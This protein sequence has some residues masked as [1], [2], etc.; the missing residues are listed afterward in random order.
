MY[1]YH[2]ILRL[3]HWV[4]ALLVLALLASGMTV[5]LLG[6][7]GVT[8]LLGEA[9]RDML[10]EYHKTFGILVLGLMAIRLL[11]RFE[12]GK[13]E[14]EE[15]PGLLIR[16]ISGLVHYLL[17][18]ALFA[19]AILGLLATD[20]MDYPIEF[21][22]WNLP[23]VITIDKPMGE[24]LYLAHTYVGWALLVLVGL[25]VAG[26]LKHGFVHHD[27]ILSRMRPF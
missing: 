4:I 22:S 20:A 15:P 23:Q 24:T 5:W 18:V 14:Y 17:Y 13:P 12:A 3:L 26:A 21:F 27:G 9:R 1:R 16:A 19:Q 11:V 6:F 10:Y 2:P 25:H 7:D 8:R